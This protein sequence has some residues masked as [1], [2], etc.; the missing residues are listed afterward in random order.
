MVEVAAHTHRARAPGYGD[1]CKRAHFIQPSSVC[2]LER[3]VIAVSDP[4]AA[5]ALDCFLPDPE[6]TVAKMKAYTMFQ[7]RCAQRGH[8]ALAKLTSERNFGK[9]LVGVAGF[10]GVITGPRAHGQPRTWL[11]MRLRTAQ[12]RKAGDD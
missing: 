4:F 7:S 12:E 6:G 5:M 3:E 8:I 10:E 9:K 1:L 2:V 11:G